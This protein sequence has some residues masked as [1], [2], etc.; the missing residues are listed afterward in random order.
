MIN[1]VYKCSGFIASHHHRCQKWKNAL[2]IPSILRLKCDKLYESYRVCSQHF[3]PQNYLTPTRLLHHA[4]PDQN[5][6]G[7]GCELIKVN[8]GYICITT[9]FY[10]VASLHFT[11]NRLDIPHRERKKCIRS[12]CF[13]RFISSDYFLSWQIMN[14]VHNR[15]LS[16]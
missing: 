15:F 12:E 14:A 13:H 1:I 11:V 8:V 3:S 16:L 2:C 5:L 4:C 9:I 6:P 7:K 10:A